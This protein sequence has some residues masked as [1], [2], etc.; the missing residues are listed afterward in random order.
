MLDFANKVSGF[1]PA[2]LIAYV[3][4]GFVPQNA[5]TATAGGQPSGTSCNASTQVGAMPYSLQTT[6]FGVGVTLSGYV[7]TNQ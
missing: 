5:A 3:Q 7:G 1:T 2:A 4:A 6:I